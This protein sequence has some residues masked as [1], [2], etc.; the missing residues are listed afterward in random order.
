MP[1]LSTARLLSRA[2]GGATRRRSLRALGGAALAAA[3]VGPPDYAT[4]RRKKKRKKRNGES[5]EVREQQRCTLD[6]AACKAT[7]LNECPPHLDCGF[8]LACCE[9]CDATG[10]LACV[11]GVA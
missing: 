4:A 6:V 8:A 2:A 7:A 9:S 11:L 5:C 10:L 1:E 3:T